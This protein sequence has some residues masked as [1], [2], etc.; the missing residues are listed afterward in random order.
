MRQATV[1]QFIEVEDKIIGPI[2]VRQFILLVIAGLIMF[3][4]YKLSDMA[5]FLLTGI[6]TAAIFLVIAFIKINSMP[7]HYFALNVLQ[8]FKRPKLRR[9]ARD[10]NTKTK[11][12]KEKE[13]LMPKKEIVSKKIVTRSR[14]SDLS[15]IIDTGGVYKGEVAQMSHFQN[16]LTDLEIK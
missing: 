5:L 15:L 12:E 11:E 1:P 14:L 9:W 8:T 7:F 4:E 6:P 3:L 10:L 13:E 2:T 16:D